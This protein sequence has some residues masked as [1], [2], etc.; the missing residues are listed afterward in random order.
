[1]GA[2]VLI[3]RQHGLCRAGAEGHYHSEPRLDPKFIL[4]KPDTLG[5]DRRHGLGRFEPIFEQAILVTIDTIDDLFHTVRALTEELNKLERLRDQV[6][7]AEA[8]ANGGK[9]IGRA[10]IDHDSQI[11]KSSPVHAAAERP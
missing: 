6:R 11:R 4:H 10:P 8:I 3:A 9:E 7:A 5:F 2:R 1:L